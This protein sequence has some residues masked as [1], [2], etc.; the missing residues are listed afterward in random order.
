M[1]Q[2]YRAHVK[3]FAQV[4]QQNNHSAGQRPSMGNKRIVSNI[5]TS[6]QSTGSSIFFMTSTTILLTCGGSTFFFLFKLVTDPIWCTMTESV[7]HITYITCQRNDAIN[8]SLKIQKYHQEW[9]KLVVHPKLTLLQYQ[10]FHFGTSITALSSV[11]AGRL[12]RHAFNFLS[13]ETSSSSNDRECWLSL[14]HRKS[15]DNHFSPPKNPLQ[16]LSVISDINAYF[17]SSNQIGLNTGGNITKSNKKM[18]HGDAAGRQICLLYTL[19]ERHHIAAPGL[20]SSENESP[21]RTDVV[22]LVCLMR[23]GT[24]CFSET[25][26]IH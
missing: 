23:A 10:Y 8:C 13:V 17:P 14:S 16:E 24:L 22:L 2:I 18:K 12:W 7:N 21:L 6:A 4:K 20:V 9:I 3:C 25:L 26:N 5:S 19:N 1:R 15:I 11:E